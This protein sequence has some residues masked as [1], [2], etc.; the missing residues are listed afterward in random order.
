VSAPVV[1]CPKGIA[2]SQFWSGHPPLP[3]T[4]DPEIRAYRSGDLNVNIQLAAGVASVSGGS[5]PTDHFWLLATGGIFGGS[6]L[7][8]LYCPSSFSLFGLLIDAPGES[9]GQSRRAHAQ[10][11]PLVRAGR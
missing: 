10:H 11:G 3:G 6:G 9:R 2:T 8:P 5:T 4:A 7:Q 1:H